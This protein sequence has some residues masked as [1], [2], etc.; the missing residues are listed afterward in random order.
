FHASGDVRERNLAKLTLGLAPIIFVS[1]H[2]QE[3]APPRFRI[4]QENSVVWKNEVRQQLDAFRF[5]RLPL[6]SRKSQVDRPD[7]RR[8]VELL[9]IADQSGVKFRRGGV[10][11]P[12]SRHFS[13]RQIP[14]PCPQHLGFGKQPGSTSG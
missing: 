1:D 5:E 11:W 8:S 2:A 7:V 14:V 10:G 4:A 12:R 3:T 6:L 13:R 9:C